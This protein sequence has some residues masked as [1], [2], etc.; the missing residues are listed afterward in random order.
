MN[1]TLK[2][3]IKSHRDIARLFV[4]QIVEVDS[5]SH[6]PQ[7]ELIGIEKNRCS[8][9]NFGFVV[10]YSFGDYIQ[11]ITISLDTPMDLRMALGTDIEFEQNDSNL[12]RLADLKS[13]LIPGFSLNYHNNRDE[14]KLSTEYLKS[15][16]VEVAE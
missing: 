5:S 4:G 10:D 8:K 13:S 16:G 3:D 15:V 11:Q 7:L 1:I 12:G 9:G 14:I 2:A 6:L